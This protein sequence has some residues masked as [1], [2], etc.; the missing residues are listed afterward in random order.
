M[1]SPEKIYINQDGKMVR[2][3]DPSAVYLLHGVGDEIPDSLYDLFLKNNNNTIS[4]IDNRQKRITKPK[5]SRC[6]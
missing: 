2:E 1:R 4:K 6:E 5:A 3:N